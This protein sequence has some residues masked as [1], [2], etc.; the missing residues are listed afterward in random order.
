[1]F[2]DKSRDIDETEGLKLWCMSRVSAEANFTG[3][4]QKRHE[5]V[6]ATELLSRAKY[7][8]L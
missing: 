4:K 2:Q 7:P 6:K 3:E 1:M 8:G 5:D